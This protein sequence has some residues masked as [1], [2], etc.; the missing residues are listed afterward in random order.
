[1]SVP[2]SNRVIVSHLLPK[3]RISIHVK[4]EIFVLNSAVVFSDILFSKCHFM[5]IHIK[6]VMSP[7]L[8][9]FRN[10]SQDNPL[11]EK[12]G[13]VEYVTCSLELS[14]ANSADESIQ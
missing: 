6:Y 8:C 9:Q 2:Q 4:N 3:A 12:C 11:V 10:T 14:M 13:T 1:M 7:K 5:C